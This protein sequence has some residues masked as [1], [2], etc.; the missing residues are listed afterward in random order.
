[1]GGREGDGEI[2]AAG[3]AVNVHDLAGEVESGDLAG[4]HGVRIDFGERDAADGDDRLLH[5]PRLQV[6]ELQP[7][8]VETDLDRVVAH[9]GVLDVPL[10]VVD[11]RAGESERLAVDL[12]LVVEEG[13]SVG[14]DHLGASVLEA[15]SG[16]A[17]DL[18]LARLASQAPGALRD[19]LVSERLREVLSVAD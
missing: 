10:A 5:G 12:A 13:A 14:R 9:L 8:A 18:R 7:L 1:M 4:L 6:L 15:A 3:R 19:D 11:G 17:G 16:E 2:V